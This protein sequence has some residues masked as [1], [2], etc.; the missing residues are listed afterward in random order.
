MRT[1]LNRLGRALLATGV[2]A[3]FAAGS[4][5]VAAQNSV[6]VMD[7]ETIVRAARPS[8]VTVVA[9]R[10]TG[11]AATAKRPATRRLRSSIGSGVAIDA[12]VI[13]TTASVVQR[14]EKVFVRSADGV[15][16]EGQVIGFDLVYN[17]A[18]IRTPGARFQPL[19]FANGRPPQEGDWVVALGTSYRDQ[20]TTSFGTVSVRY[21]EPRFGLIQLSNSVYPGNSGAAALNSRG[22]LIGIVQGDL[23]VPDPAGRFSESLRRPGGMS[24]VLPV[25]IARPVC[26]K[27]R[28]EGRVPH[29]YLGVS[30]RSASVESETEPGSPVPIGALVESVVPGAPAQ[31]LGL[32]R[33]DLIVGF[34]GERVEYADQ[35]ARW[36]ATAAPGTAV[37]I[38][39][40]RGQTPHTGRVTL[41]DSPNAAPVW[42]MGGAVAAPESTSGQRRIA[43]LERQI[44]ELSNELQ[45]L[46]SSS[47]RR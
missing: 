9:Q 47:D 21:R 36:V 8:V 46:K 5:P 6:S 35:I 29:G 24:F 13:L 37:E 41:T 10:W 43:D 40:V 11:Q 18:L 42:A 15:E 25:E 19:R 20:P 31:K 2:L 28:T 30:T 7:V 23:G 26:E 16:R 17:V 12:D 45:K 22:E 3:A 33:G 27:L 44:L 4:R 1:G 34:D 14:S 32:K 39:Y 38:V